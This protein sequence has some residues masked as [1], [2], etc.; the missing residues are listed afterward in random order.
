MEVFITSLFLSAHTKSFLFDFFFHSL[1][2]RKLQTIS[3]IL[4]VVHLQNILICMRIGLSLCICASICQH[5]FVEKDLYL[6]P[7]LS[8]LLLSVC[9]CGFLYVNTIILFVSCGWRSREF[10]AHWVERGCWWVDGNGGEST[11]AVWWMMVRGFSSPPPL[12]FP[13]PQPPCH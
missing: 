11:V 10:W 2:E 12:L 6:F 4:R 8:A 5:L 3:V 13:S 9:I 1:S 7:Y